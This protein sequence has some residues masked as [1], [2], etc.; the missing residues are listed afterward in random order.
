MASLRRRLA[1]AALLVALAPT[2]GLA[3]Q[4]VNI[5][6]SEVA[7]GTTDPT[8]EGFGFSAGDP[9]SFEDTFVDDGASPGDAHLLAGILNIGTYVDTALIDAAAATTYGGADKITTIDV[10]ATF[11]SPL[12][13]G[14]TIVLQALLNS[15]LQGSTSVSTA[16]AADNALQIVLDGLSFNG[17]RFYVE[18]DFGSAFYI[19]D[20]RVDVTDKQGPPQP[21][22]VPATAL[23]IGI[24]A[25]GLGWARQ[26]GPRA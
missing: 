17:L 23:L 20:L 26:R 22:P 24:G 14:E 7:L 9:S 4:L 11:L 13:G 12:P 5:D 6:F 16:T 21:N 1:A 8:I 18:R 2:A 25:L 15:V 3:A 19:D 10:L